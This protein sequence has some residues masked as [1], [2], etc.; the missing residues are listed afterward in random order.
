LQLRQLFVAAV[1]AGVGDELAGGGD[2]G[3]GG[4][5]VAFGEREAGVA[6]VPG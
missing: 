2:V 4:G 3:A 6:E 5:G 1:V